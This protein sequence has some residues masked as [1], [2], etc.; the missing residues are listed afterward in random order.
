LATRAAGKSASDHLSDDARARRPRGLEA[1]EGRT[2]LELLK[3]ELPDLA[4]IDVGLPGL[5]GWQIASSFRKEPASDRVL[6]AAL[7]GH[8]TPEAHERSRPAGFDLHLIEPIDPDVVQN[9]LVGNLPARTRV[10]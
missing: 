2:G 8:G 10:T 3:T 6:L 4:V 7:T 9:L 5:D 1:E